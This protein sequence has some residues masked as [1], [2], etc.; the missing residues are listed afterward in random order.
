M[1]KLRWLL[2]IIFIPS[3]QTIQS[4]EEDLHSPLYRVAPGHDRQE[5]FNSNSISNL[6]LLFG[7]SLLLCLRSIALSLSK[8]FSCQCDSIVLVSG[9]T[10]HR[11]WFTGLL[12]FKEQTDKKDCPVG[13]VRWSSSC[14]KF[15]DNPLSWPEAVSKCNAMGK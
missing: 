14:Y 2:I 4:A 1:I 9:A 5:E 13:W 12:N 15:D 8:F 11:L 6:K 3:F 10:I 7:Q